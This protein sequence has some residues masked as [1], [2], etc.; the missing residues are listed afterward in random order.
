M[1]VGSAGIMQEDR[2]QKA[3]EVHIFPVAMRGIGE[4]HYD[5]TFSPKAR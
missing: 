4:G 2:T 1:F 5:W 3:I